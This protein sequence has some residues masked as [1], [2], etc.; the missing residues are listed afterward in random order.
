MCCCSVERK[1]EEKISW[2]LERN[3]MKWKKKEKL[4][5]LMK[6]KTEEIEIFI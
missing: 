3:K 5:I 6:E 2:F 1:N 4:L